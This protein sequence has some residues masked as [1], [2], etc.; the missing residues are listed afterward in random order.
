MSRVATDQPKRFTVQEYLAFERGSAEKHELR[1]GELVA[2]AGGTPEHS[3]II[4][5]VT[6][7]LRNRLKGKPC[8]VYES[9]LRVRP[10]RSERYTYPDVSV[11]C[12]DLRRDPLDAEGQTVTN[13]RVI[14]EVLS[15]ST[16]SSDRGEKFRRYLLIDTLEEYVLVAQSNPRVETFL[17]QPDGTWSFAYH[18]GLES[19]ARLRSLGVDLPLTEIYAGVTF[20]PPEPEGPGPF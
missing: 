20:P 11:F 16:E 10:P 9:N 17:R 8:R 13:P 5:N 1:D 2:M 18:D 4:A 7:E 6:G 12:T 3:L 14:V 19:T 15:K